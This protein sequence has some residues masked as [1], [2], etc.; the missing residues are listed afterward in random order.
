MPDR[1]WYST[2]GGRSGASEALPAES[3]REEITARARRQ[4]Q[5]VLLLDALAQ[6]LGARCPMKSPST[7][8]GGCRRSGGRAS[9]SR[10]KLSM[11]RAKIGAL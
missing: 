8:R 3:L 1:G 6:Q 11:P 5:T 4:V 2:T 10:L 9:A 7:D